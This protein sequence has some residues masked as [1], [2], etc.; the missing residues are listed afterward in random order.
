[1][2]RITRGAAVRL[3]V[4][5]AALGCLASARADLLPGKDSMKTW[6]L[7]H[8][9]IDVPRNWEMCEADGGLSFSTV[10]G[11]G[12]ERMLLVDEIEIEIKVPAAQVE[13]SLI[14]AFYD[15]LVTL[16]EETS[17]PGTVVWEPLIL[18]GEQA[19]L[20]MYRLPGSRW[21]YVDICYLPEHTNVML[22]ITY[23][24]SADSM[25]RAREQAISFFLTVWQK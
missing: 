21:S 14:A 20:V 11:D 1:M 18:D 2:R 8:F 25:D 4:L 13:D 24:E 19:L 9:T 15:D 7:G 6:D 12:L 23:G 10:D 5:L 22:Y 3:I 17:M 16:Q